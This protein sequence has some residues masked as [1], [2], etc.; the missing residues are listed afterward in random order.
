MISKAYVDQAKQ[1]RNQTQKLFQD[2]LYHSKI[3]EVGWD[4]QS[5]ELLLSELSTMD[6]NN[7]KENI[8]VGERE[9]RVF[10]S[11]VASRHFY[12]SH[13]IGRSGDIAAEQPKAA[14]SSVIYQLTNKLSLD[15]LRISGIK[16]VNSCLVVPLATGMTLTN[17]LLTLRQDNPKAKYVVWP[18]IDQKTCLKCIY[19]AGYQP[20]VIENSQEG[21]QLRTNLEEIENKMAQNPSEILCVLSTT[22]CFAP[23]GYD[24]VIEIAQLCQKYNISHV[25]N[26]A[27]GLQDTKCTHLINEAIRLGR[28]DFIVQSTDKN[29]MVPVGGAIVASPNEKQIEKFSRLYPGRA[30]MSPILDTFIT[31]LSMGKGGFNS[32]LLERKK[33]FTYFSEKLSIIAEKHGER[34]L[35]TPNNTI[36]MGMTLSTFQPDSTFIGSMLFSRGCSGLRVVSCK[37]T[38]TIQDLTFQGYGSHTDHY[39]TPYLTVA[40][41][42]GITQ[43]DIDTF[44][45]RLD[46]TLS[47]WHKKHTTPKTNT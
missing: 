34:L 31:L 3:P 16:R 2:L 47:E 11:I 46:K 13:G 12:L 22:S 44:T 7:F 23:R 17:C 39:P 41:A 18:R 9:G 45:A 43:S 19:S 21:D 10:S 28:V 27:Y 42:I 5:I 14:G 33:L 15:L 8:G 35:L 37:D 24:R 4:N 25:I 6:S 40:A 38:K 36:S 20:I 1:A 32:L 26:N 30:S 29:L